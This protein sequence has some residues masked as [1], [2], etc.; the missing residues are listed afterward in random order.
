MRKKIL[1]LVIF[2]LV[3]QTAAYSAQSQEARNI[4]EL[5]M[6]HNP[7]L[8]AKQAASYA[9]IV[10]E[11][12]KKYNQDP[13]AIAAIIVH[14]STVRNDA[15]SKGGDYGLMQIRWKV[16]EKAI[17]QK[18]PNVK[19]ASDMFD[20]RTNIFFGTEIFAYCMSK[21]ED[22]KGGLMKYSAGSTKLTSKVLA[23]VSELKARKK[24]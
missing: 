11:A 1:C 9:G 19:K 16:H 23:T 18:Y 15:V 13:Y 17:K 5:F 20:A 12:A 22:L 8:T 14:E 21:S 6:K 24:K 3:L 4:S 2:A 7:K 10:I